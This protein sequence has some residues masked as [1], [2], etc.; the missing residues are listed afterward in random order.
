[1]KRTGIGSDHTNENCGNGRENNGG[2][3]SIKGRWTPFG[4]FLQRMEKIPKWEKKK[5]NDHCSSNA[6][7]QARSTKPATSFF[8]HKFVL[9][10]DSSIGSI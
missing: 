10:G 1:M 5:H 9:H 4:I 6:P 8:F 3:L 2:P 7:L